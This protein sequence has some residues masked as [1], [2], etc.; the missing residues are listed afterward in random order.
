MSNLVTNE[1][2]QPVLDHI[3][4]NR[5][6]AIERLQE[7]LRIPSISTDPEYADEV[8]RCAEHLAEDLRSI[9][10]ETTVH[11]TKGHPMVVATDDSAGSNAP[12]ELY[13]GHYD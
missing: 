7:L 4:Q 2:L 6:Q 10:L 1:T 11:N 9:G 12:R 8:H 13:Y 3:E 5:N